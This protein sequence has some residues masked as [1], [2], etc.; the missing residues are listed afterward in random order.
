[1]VNEA[2][3]MA[4]LKTYIHKERKKTIDHARSPSSKE[5]WQTKTIQNVFHAHRAAALFPTAELGV[6]QFL[7]T[8]EARTEKEVGLEW[9]VQKLGRC[10]CIIEQC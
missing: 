4:D 10:N 2:M 3:K 6:R 9:E 1:M 8:Q 5:G 7:L